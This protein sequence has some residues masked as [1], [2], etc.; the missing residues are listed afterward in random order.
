LILAFKAVFLWK[1]QF[2]R[3]SM[4]QESL[5]LSRLKTNPNASPK[6]PPVAFDT[7]SPCR[8]GFSLAAG[9]AELVP[10]MVETTPSALPK[11]SDEEDPGDFRLFEMQVELEEQIQSRLPN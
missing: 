4:A 10:M 5:Q 6:K 8:L 3:I 11:E 7:Q 9:P 2:P 1:I